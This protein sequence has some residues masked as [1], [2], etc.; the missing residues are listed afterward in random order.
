MM[1]KITQDPTNLYKTW[2]S[3][4]SVMYAECSQKQD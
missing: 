4:E 1:T 2:S 3:S